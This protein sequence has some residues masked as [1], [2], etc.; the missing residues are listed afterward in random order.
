MNSAF[1]S[2]KK[3][4]PSRQESIKQSTASLRVCSVFGFF[5]NPDFN[6]EARKK[7]NGD[8]QFEFLQSAWIAKTKFSGLTEES[9]PLLGNRE[10]IPGC[11][12]TGNFTI[13]SDG[14]ACTT[15]H[16]L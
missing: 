2:T 16:N 11:P 3:R 14:G 13:P 4:S 7:W 8:R 1:G 15:C 12:V 5:P 10:S 6:E 9:D